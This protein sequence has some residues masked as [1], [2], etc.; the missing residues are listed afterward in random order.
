MASWIHASDDSKPAAA[1]RRGRWQ[2]VPLFVWASAAFVLMVV[3]ASIAAPLVSPYD[4]VQQSLRERL[5]GP[6]WFPEAGRHRHLLGTDQLGRDV[7]S[8]IIYGSRVSL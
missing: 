8:R 6:T 7:L 2:K 5:R 4:P 1:G 3:I